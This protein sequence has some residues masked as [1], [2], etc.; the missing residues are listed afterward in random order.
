MFPGIAEGENTIMQHVFARDSGLDVARREVAV[1]Q[2]RDQ[3]ATRPADP[4]FRYGFGA[5]YRE[6]PPV[7]PIDNPWF[8]ELRDVERTTEHDFAIRIFPANPWRNRAVRD[9]AQAGTEVARA[10]YQTAKMR[11]A[12]AVLTE[13]LNLRQRS[14]EMV[15]LDQI[16][17]VRQRR[18]QYLAQRAEH[19]QA[20][21]A[22][23]LEAAAD[24]LAARQDLSAG[25][26]QQAQVLGA[27]AARSGLEKQQILTLLADPDDMRLATTPDVQGR[28]PD[29]TGIFRPEAVEREWAVQQARAALREAKFDRRPWI[30]HVQAGYGYDDRAGRNE[31]WTVQGAISIPLFSRIYPKDRT[32]EA[33]FAAALARQLNTENQIESELVKTQLAWESALSS[34]R[35]ALSNA[36]PIL[37]EIQ[38]TL[39]ALEAQPGINVSTILALEETTLRTRLSLIRLRFNVQRAI[40][41]A[42]A[43][44]GLISGTF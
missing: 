27:L 8:S 39:A 4:E 29:A 7:S 11:L 17:T 41:D 1:A 3:S 9:G 15:L 42:D 22:A 10:R 16:V 24:W 21:R 34:Y 37:R 33:E 38:E 25:K 18:H 19:E 44:R 12:H 36:E 23:V 2:S 13:I 20:T 43:A 31:E 30:S 5:R 40:L 28:I 35:E 32:A 26:A 14:S 6:S